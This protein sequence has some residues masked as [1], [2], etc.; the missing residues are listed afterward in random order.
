MSF[1][2]LSKESLLAQLALALEQQQR[3]DVA[4]FWNQHRRRVEWLDD[5]GLQQQLPVWRSS[6][7]V[8]PCNNRE[9]VVHGRTL[10]AA[11]IDFCNHC[12]LAAPTP[13]GLHTF[14][15]KSKTHVSVAR[16]RTHLPCCTEDER[17]WTLKRTRR[18]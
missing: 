9:V 14:S 3:G 4:L 5:A 12:L 6:C 7:A 16:L 11:V 15:F 2:V 13:A 17:S 10:H 1:T 18:M 8:L